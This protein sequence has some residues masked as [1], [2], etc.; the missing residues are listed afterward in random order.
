MRMV[1]GGPVSTK[2]I[3]QGAPCV[4]GAHV[5]RAERFVLDG[6]LRGSE[7]EIGN[8][9][10]RTRFCARCRRFSPRR[11]S[12]ADRSGRPHWLRPPRGGR[13]YPR[14]RKQADSPSFSLTRALVLP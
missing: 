10:G 7:L 5:S 13:P 9:G 4:R 2:N 6:S 14:S 1:V 8:S 3:T 12:T 11:S